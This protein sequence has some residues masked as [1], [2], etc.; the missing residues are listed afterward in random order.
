MRTSSGLTLVPDHSLADAPGPHTL[1]VPVGQGTRH[2]DPHLTAW[3]REHGPHARRL[4]SVRT[5]AIR[6]WRTKRS[7]TPSVCT[8]SLL[9]AAA[10]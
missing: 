10:G 4:V 1:L 6:R 2:L 9:L 3:L 5:G 8:G 7:W